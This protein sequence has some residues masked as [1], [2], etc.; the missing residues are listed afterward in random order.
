MCSNEK[1]YE[2]E[3]KKTCENFLLRK[4]IPKSLRSLLLVSLEMLSALLYLRWLKFHVSKLVSLRLRS[5]AALLC[6]LA[7]THAHIAA[8]VSALVLLRLA[9]GWMGGKNIV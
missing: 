6:S 5:A 7:Y 2:K 8:R 9:D 3:E 1:E 4:K